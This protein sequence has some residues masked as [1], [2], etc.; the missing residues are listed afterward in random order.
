MKTHLPSVAQE[1]VDLDKDDIRV[2]QSIWTEAEM[3]SSTPGVRERGWSKHH[4]AIILAWPDNNGKI[5]Y[6]GVWLPMA[7]TW[8]TMIITTS[9]WV[10]QYTFQPYNTFKIWW[11]KTL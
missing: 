7:G 10:R 1:K 9:S 4:T 3:G 5:A 11:S 2:L 6:S 8:Q